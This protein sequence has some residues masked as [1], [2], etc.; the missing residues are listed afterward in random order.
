MQAVENCPLLGYYAEGSG[1]ALPA[2]GDNLS[3]PYPTDKSF[4]FFKMGSMGCAETSLRNSPEERNSHLLRGGRVK[5]SKQFI[6]HC[7]LATTITNLPSLHICLSPNFPSVALLVWQ[8]SI[9]TN[10]LLKTFVTTTLQT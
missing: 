9:N 7:C 1:E 4:G 2:F 3:F 5:Y 8:N 6:M 10:V